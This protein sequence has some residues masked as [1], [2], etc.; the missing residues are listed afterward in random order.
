MALLLKIFRVISSL[1]FV[2][3]GGAPPSPAL[4][5]KNIFIL[6]FLLR[7]LAFFL[8]L[9]PSSVCQSFVKAAISG[10]WDLSDPLRECIRR[11]GHKET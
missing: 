2:T 11:H 10:L 6:G 1:V 8:M 3:T 4:I 7:F 9:F 5:Q